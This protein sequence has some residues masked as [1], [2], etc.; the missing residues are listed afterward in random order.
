MIQ[1]LSQMPLKIGGS[2]HLHFQNIDSMWGLPVGQNWAWVCLTHE[3]WVTCLYPSSKG[4]DY[5]VSII[6]STLH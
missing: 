5:L 6:T 4:C 2:S 1:Y 3:N